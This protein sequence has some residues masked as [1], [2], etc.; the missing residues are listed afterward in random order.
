MREII[1]HC[2]KCKKIVLR[3]VELTL[4]ES[5]DMFRRYLGVT[6]DLAK[7]KT[8]CPYCHSRLSV[9]FDVGVRVEYDPRPVVSSVSA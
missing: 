2:P 9:M 5:S 1:A 7:F 4:G 6:V 3:N 8:L